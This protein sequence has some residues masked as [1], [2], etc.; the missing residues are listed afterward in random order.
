MK[1]PKVLGTNKK[2]KLEN[3]KVTS[4]TL[5]N[6]GA[7]TPPFKETMDEVN[8]FLS[9]YGAFHRG[10]GP[11]AEITY[12]KVC[13]SVKDIGEFLGIR[14][15]QSLLFTHNTS[16][17][18]NLF[19][20]M[21]NLQKEDVVLTSDIEHTSN[22]LPWSYNTKAKVIYIKSFIDGGLDYG[23]LEK[24]VLRYKSKIRLVTITGASNMSGYIPDLKKIS[25]I[26]K[27]TTAFLFVDGAQLAPHQEIDM[28]KQKIDALAFSAH[29]LY[30][31]FGIGVLAVPTQL[32][33]QV[34]VDPG[35]GSVDMISEN[36]IVWAPDNAKHQTG[37][38]NV[39]GIVAT[40][41]SCTLLKEAGW[42]N[43]ISHEIKLTKYALDKLQKINKLKLFVEPK[44]FLDQNRIGAIVFS[45][46]GYHHALLSSVLENEYGIETRA[47]TICN[48]KLVRRWFNISNKEQKII[49]KKI[50][51]G[52]RLASY[53]VVRLS[54]GIH[55]TKSDIDRLVMAL[56]NIS[57]RG[58]ELRYRANKKEEA[59]DVK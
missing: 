54:I 24:Q 43:I 49:D 51:Q 2:I 31:P 47:G 38:W 35:G 32:L 15:D 8:D 29:K 3:G 11:Y 45:L 26:I 17:A 50:E 20:R 13:Q 59:Y 52:D 18:I 22:N 10:A 46:K 14:K 48:H 5:L 55:N 27:F 33:K 44:L 58:H 16:S 25:K 57:K 9:T 41:K 36:S 12:Q 21:L 7:T 40:A 19:A 1:F 53:G 34:P 30:A 4:V 6:N 42:D 39:T 37:T 28:K 23:D 56:V